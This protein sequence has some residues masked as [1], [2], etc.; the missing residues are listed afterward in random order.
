MD[1]EPGI[2]RGADF[3]GIETDEPPDFDVWDYPAPLGLAN[4]SEAWRW[5]KYE[6]AKPLGI[7]ELHVT[8]LG[9][10]CHA[11]KMTQDCQLTSGQLMHAACVR[12]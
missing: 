3:E 7:D 5:I 4:P 12:R 1:G 11:F 2:E 6:G 10:I 8:R 9:W